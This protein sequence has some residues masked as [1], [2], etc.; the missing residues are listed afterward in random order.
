VGEASA[1]EA[2]WVARFWR[3]WGMDLEGSSCLG[4]CSSME[5]EDKPKV[6]AA[7]LFLLFRH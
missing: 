1:S 6:W 5:T 2:Y 7:Q 3:G 4:F